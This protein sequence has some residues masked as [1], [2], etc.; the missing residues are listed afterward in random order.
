MNSVSD[1]FCLIKWHLRAEG[2][3]WLVMHLLCKHENLSL[4]PRTHE[5]RSVMGVVACPPSTG[6]DGYLGLLA[7]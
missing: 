3:V 2:T 1:Y 6:E 5:N 4:I 7:S